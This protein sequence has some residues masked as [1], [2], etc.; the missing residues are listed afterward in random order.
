MNAE[1]ILPF[2]VV[3]QPGSLLPLRASPMLRLLISVKVMM[4]VS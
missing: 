3:K 4:S 1:A 2:R